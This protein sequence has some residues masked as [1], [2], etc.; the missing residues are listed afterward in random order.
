M[1]EIG[2][3]WQ[4]GTI[5][6]HM[7]NVFVD[8]E[9]AKFIWKP[10]LIMEDQKIIFWSLKIAVMAFDISSATKRISVDSTTH[11]EHVTWE[12]EK[13]ATFHKS[14]YVDEQT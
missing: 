14:L 4:S 9:C 10:P 11:F 3:A 7:I 6:D 13:C 2:K 1:E 8:D 12:R 5:L